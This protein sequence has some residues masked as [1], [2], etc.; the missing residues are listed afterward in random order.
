[1]RVPQEFFG[2][3][4]VG[5]GVFAASVQLCAAHVALPTCD[6]KGDDDSVTNGQLAH[7]TAHLHDLPHELMTQHVS[8]L[9]GRDESVVQVKV[10]ATNGSA[11]HSHDDVVRVQNLGFRNVD[12]AD[13]PFMVKTV[14]LHRHRG[15]FQI[16]G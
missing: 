9:Q 14:S 11:R 4:R 16:L 2:D 3:P 8:L 6:G 1:R 5:V 10:G 15:W 13:L 12:Y 7:A